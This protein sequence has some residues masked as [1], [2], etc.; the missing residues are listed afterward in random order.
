MLSTK[1]SAKVGQSIYFTV[2]INGGTSEYVGLYE[3]DLEENTLSEVA[4][5]N[6]CRTRLLF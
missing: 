2:V 6:Q 1:G 3:I 5:D 4:R